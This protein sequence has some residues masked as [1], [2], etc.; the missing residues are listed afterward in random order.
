MRRADAPVILTSGSQALL[1]GWP[2]VI[3]SEASEVEGFRRA[4]KKS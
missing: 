4:T 1:H 3:P 2:A